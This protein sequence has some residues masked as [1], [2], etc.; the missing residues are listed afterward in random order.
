MNPFVAT[1]TLYLPSKSTFPLWPQPRSHFLL[2]TELFVSECHWWPNQSQSKELCVQND[3]GCVCSNTNVK[4]IFWGV[5]K[6]SLGTLQSELFRKRPFWRERPLLLS[7]SVSLPGWLLGGY[8]DEDED[9]IYFTADDTNDDIYIMMQCL[10]V[11]HEKWALFCGFFMGYQ[12]SLMV[13]HGFWLVSMVFKV[14][15]WFFMVFGWFPWFS[16]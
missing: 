10:S 12:G 1:V 4:D 11:C 13:F 7:Y 5:T 14:V 6:T 8:R 15:S 16:R 2:F 9:D 3:I